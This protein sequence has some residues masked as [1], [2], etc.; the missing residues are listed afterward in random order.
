V[1]LAALCVY[2]TFFLEFT[3]VAVEFCS[4]KAPF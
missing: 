1:D 4:R 2:V 3:K